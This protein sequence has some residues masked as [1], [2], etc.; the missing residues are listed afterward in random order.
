MTVLAGLCRTWL[1]PNLLVSHA[2]SQIYISGLALGTTYELS[3]M[4]YNSIGDGEYQVQF[5]TAKTSS[6]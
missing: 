3:V 4:A 2:N 5:L 6:K 1:E